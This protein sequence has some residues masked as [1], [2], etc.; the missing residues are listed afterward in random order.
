[1]KTISAKVKA[2]AAGL[3]V[4]VAAYVGLAIWQQAQQISKA[5]EVTSTLVLVEKKS[6]LYL[7]VKDARYDVA[8]VQQYLQDM[9]ATRGLDGLDDGPELASKA[10]DA[11]EAD[12]SR[13]LALAKEL[14]LSEVVAELDEARKA[15]PAYFDTGMAMSQAY[16]AGGPA[17]GNPMM[18]GFDA[19]ASSVGDA[20]EKLAETV[21]KESTDALGQIDAA[22]LGSADG[23]VQAL[24]VTAVFSVIIVLALGVVAMMGMQIVSPIAS[25]TAVMQKLAAGD[26]SARI[27]VAKRSDEI[28]QMIETIEVF[29]QGLIET[30]TLRAKQVEQAKQAEAERRA[31]LREMASS[32][33]TEAGAAVSHVGEETTAM[34][35]LANAMSASAANVTEQCQGAAS[36]AEQAMMSASSV[37]AATEEFAASIQEVTTQISRAKEITG[38]TVKTS[39]RTREAVANLS[40]AVDRIGE[41]AGIISDIA[42]QTNLLA[43]NA[44]IEAAR[45]GEAGRG[46]AVVASEVK[47]LSMQ[48]ATSTDD[49]RR[50]IDEIQ[51][52]TRETSEVVS[53]ISLQISNVDEVSTAIS[54]AMEE[55]SATMGEIARHVAETATA[56]GY[57]SQSVSVVLGEAGRTGESARAL[58][59]SAKDVAGSIVGLRETI[60]RVVRAA[61]A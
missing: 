26:Y 51:R 7:A 49:I 46:F 30:E 2:G 3:L 37:T 58:S 48:T 50:H 40:K 24:I 14:G 33:E 18:P 6:E 59:E 31:S 21:R 9:S 12:T 23:A 36:A 45:A 11:F 42:A 27:N 38:E 41:V 25:V 13:A 16:V 61:A 39:N 10:A 19:A 55:Q 8:Q 57:V 28:G 44:T 22:A 35:Q 29:R 4:L 47:S 15:F 17:L 1:M 34:S 32:V 54:A 53:E 52:V 20:M 5:S 60:V 43:L 56:A